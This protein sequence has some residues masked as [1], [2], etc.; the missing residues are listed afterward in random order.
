MLQ[1]LDIYYESRADGQRQILSR[2]HKRSPLFVTSEVLCFVAAVG[3]VA[4]STITDSRW[5][6]LLLAVLSLVAYVVARI[7]DSRNTRLMQRARALLKVYE[8]EQAYRRGDF[9]VFDDGERYMDAHHP[10]TFD[11]DIFGP[12]S[13]YNRLCRT[14]TTGGSDVLARELSSVSNRAGRYALIA[15]LAARCDFREYFQSYGVENKVDTD[16]RD[17]LSQMEGVS[18]PT[19][20]V[21]RPFR[22]FAALSVAGFFVSV[23]ATVLSYIPVGVPITWGLAQFFLAWAL[24]SGP[25]HRL[26]RSVGSLH[27]RLPSFCNLVNLTVSQ[28]S[29]KAEDGQQILRQLEGA[30]EALRHFGRIVQKMDS[31]NNILGLFITDSLAMRDVLILSDFLHW[32]E[33]SASR[34]QQWADAVAMMDALVSMATFRYN[35]P[36]AVKPKVVESDGI[37]Y[38]AQSL[39]HP[40]LGRKAVSNDF[41]IADRNFY[42]ITGANMAG[43]STFLRTVGINYVMAMCG[44]PVMAKSLRIS[45]FGLFT[46]MRTTDDLTRG[47]S[48]FN[49]ELL[50]LQQ[51]LDYCSTQKRTLIILDEILKGTNSLDKL[52]GSRLFLEHV[53]QSPV[54]GIVATHDLELSKMESPRIHNFC[55]EI[56]LGA[57]VT[58]S[59]K[60]TPGVARNQNATFLLRR[61]LAD[62]N[63]EP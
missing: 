39:W 43:K 46:S 19:C 62:D 29:L 57:D 7:A 21:S 14:A 15:E 20:I 59:Y 1:S 25:L 40:F 61:M 58:Y 10:F 44:L 5:L 11:L 37:V 24:T 51:L 23:A 63:T 60:I 35:E 4:L 38:E 36:E 22:L 13:L 48:Y 18:C 12:A 2:L 31:R 42:I 32:R 47:I 33:S 55:F 41:N 6:P 53:M 9:H 34:L 3:F 49:A 27:D 30:P 8:G 45:H 52:N 54:S 17:V 28:S 56:Q 50:R 16:F 26:Q